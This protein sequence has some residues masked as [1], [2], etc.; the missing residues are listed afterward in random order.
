MLI[1]FYYILLVYQCWKSKIEPRRRACCAPILN[2]D[3]HLCQ[4]DQMELWLVNETATQIDAGPGELCGFNIGTN[5]PKPTGLLLHWLAVQLFSVTVSS[6]NY[7]HINYIFKCERQVS[8]PPLWT[9]VCR[10]N[11]RKTRTS[12][13]WWVSRARRHAAW[14]TSP[15][16]RLSSLE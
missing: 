8:L 15:A 16:M 1:I 9:R 7:F 10:S 4:T 5:A 14:Q 3:L 11:S 6:F 12:W 2:T 13:S